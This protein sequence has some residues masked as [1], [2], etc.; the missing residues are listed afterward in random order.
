MFVNLCVHS[1]F[2]L[3]MS[4]ISIDDIINFALKNK[5][6]YVCLTDF[7]NMY[8]AMEFYNKA[9][10]NNLKPIIGLHVVYENEHLYLIAKDNSGY[11]NLLKISSKIMTNQQ[12]RLNDYSESLFILT[13]DINCLTW[14]KSK[15]NCY[16]LNQTKPNPIAA[17]P[18]FYEE[19][20]DVI[21]VKALNAIANEKKLQDYDSNSNFD[22]FSLLNE[23]EAKEI[24]NSESLKN[25]NTL[26]EQCTWTLN[27]NSK[28]Y[29]IK[30]QEGKQSNILLQTMCVN[31]LNKMFAKQKN[32]PENYLY[33]LKYELEVIDKMG[34][35]DYFLVVQ[36]YV[37]YAKNKG[38][39]VGPGRGSAAGSLVAFLLGITTV[40]PI[41]NN[42][43]FER[44]L[45]PQRSTMPDI[46]V[47]FMDDRR[48]EV[49]EYLFEKY[50]KNNVA[51]IIIFQR[52][53]AKMVIRDVGRILSMNRVII[54]SICSILTDSFDELYQETKTAKALQ[55][56]QK[57]YPELFRIAIKL[58]NFPRQ[59]GLHAAGVV[60]SSVNLTD[61][62][63]IQNSADGL[64]CTQY[65]MEYLEPL[66][67]IK[68]DILGLINLTTL[69]QSI[70]AIEKNHGVK[71]N[72]YNIPLND[73]RVFN[74]ISAGNTTGIFQLESPG[75][76]RL[77]TR[78]KPSNIEDISICSALYRPGPQ[79]N[80]NIYLK[81]RTHPEEISYLNDDIRKILKPT[82]NIIIYQ[83]QVI[84]IVQKI[85]GFSLADADSFR[86]AIS[87]KQVSKL[88]SLKKSFIDGGIKNGYSEQKV[89]E[90]FDYIFEFA[91][92]GFNHSHSLAYSYISYWLAYI[93]YYYPL[94]FYSTLLMSNDASTEKI[95]QYINEAKNSGIEVLPP[96]INLSEYT[97]SIWNKQKIVLGFNVT[98]GIGVNACAKIIKTRQIQPNCQFNNLMLCIRD[99]KNNGVTFNIIKLLAESGCFDSL[100][101]EHDLYWLVNNIKVIYDNCDKIGLNGK[102]VIAMNFNNNKPSEADLIELNNR[103]YELLGISFK[104]H[105]LVQVRSKY[106][107]SGFELFSI[108]EIFDDSKNSFFHVLCVITDVRETTDSKGKKMAF[109]KIEDETRRASGIV[110][111]S[112]Y[113]KIVEQLQPKNVVVLSVRKNLQ[114]EGNLIVL[115]GRVINKI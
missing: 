72:L 114:K 84:Q 110:F 7:N 61:I 23:S 52:M 32:I 10:E 44:F 62:V 34:F 113:P 81:N 28:H 94:E 106:K 18:V 30:Y 41:K 95:N 89:N 53:K 97:F 20:D 93:A 102:P 47:D 99:L 63:P 17:R 100:N 12:Y 51:H 79:K 2:S 48:N 83:E 19:K 91:N 35:N 13:D 54:D 38:I 80:I 75:M 29:I 65:S 25:L 88:A 31:S 42:L 111:S 27:L 103:Q 4:S 68:M 16:S 82:C 21:F 109:L 26:V 74:Y 70:T 86:R 3:L 78:I 92:Y 96:N 76:T 58:L 40:D 45:N 90:I 46:D 85:A 101:K 57:E 1:Y 50:S 8:G 39:I 6:K 49:V 67:L 77:V 64:L 33:R 43:I 60:L 11:H 56:F 55:Q 36:D 15:V 37:N 107:D 69:N 108:K 115:N 22:N 87:K 24:F 59:T 14:L 104:E 9:L 66:G 112:V 5:Q 71:I 98:K 73:Q 105:P